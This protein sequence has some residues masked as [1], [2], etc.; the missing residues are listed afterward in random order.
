[1]D[2]SEREEFE[3]GERLVGEEA[4]GTRL[5]F[6]LLGLASAASSARNESSS[7]SAISSRDS[8]LRGADAFV[9]AAVA[10]SAETLGRFARLS[11]AVGVGGDSPGVEDHNHPMFFP[12]LH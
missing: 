11:C 4:L 9:G 5:Y 10:E 2:S 12:V 3:D 6:V 7:F 1:M 8:G